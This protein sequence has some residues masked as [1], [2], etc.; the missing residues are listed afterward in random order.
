MMC[1]IAHRLIRA[2]TRN[3]LMRISIALRVQLPLSNFFEQTE[4]AGPRP[5]PFH[6]RTLAQDGKFLF[7]IGALFQMGVQHRPPVCAVQASENRIDTLDRQFRPLAAINFHFERAGDPSNQSR[8]LR[9]FHLAQLPYV[10]R[11][12]AKSYSI[13]IADC[14][15]FRRR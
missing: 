1:R 12:C 13:H 15:L 11:A 14:N 5:I 9:L 2:P 10:L 4:K 6:F 7:A 8:H 3:F